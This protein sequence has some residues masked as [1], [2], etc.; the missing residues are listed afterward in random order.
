[1][2][3]HD[4]NGLFFKTG[5][6]FERSLFH[7]HKESETAS[8]YLDSSTR[9]SYP[10]YLG[11]GGP[12]VSRL[13]ILWV[14]TSPTKFNTTMGFHHPLGDSTCNG[15]KRLCCEFNHSIQYQYPVS[16]SV[17]GNKGIL[18][19]QPVVSQT[20]QSTAIMEGHLWLCDVM[21]TKSLP[22]ELPAIASSRRQRRFRAKYFCIVE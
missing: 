11:P 10:H 7:P 15:S 5:L 21:I 22:M 3:R 8:N 16:V 12:S 17:S 9:L 14:K 6:S 4:R 2:T 1:M 13:F 20:V 18:K 19:L